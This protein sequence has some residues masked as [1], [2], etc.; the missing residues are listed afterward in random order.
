MT[1]PDIHLTRVKH[2]CLHINSM[3]PVRWVLQKLQTWTIEVCVG[4]FSFPL[5][6]LTWDRHYMIY[7]LFLP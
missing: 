6:M 2:G 5:K 1:G 7:L 4:L 3:G